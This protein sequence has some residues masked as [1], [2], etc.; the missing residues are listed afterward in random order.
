M[1][2]TPPKLWQFPNEDTYRRASVVHHRAVAQQARTA[3][4]R[5]RRSRDIK[6][7]WAV[8]QNTVNFLAKLLWLVRWVF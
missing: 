8:A 7:C 1:L 3:L 4:R 6:M 5:Y 2:S